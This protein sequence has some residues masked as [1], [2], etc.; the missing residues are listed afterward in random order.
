MPA[1]IAAM[2]AV[3]AMSRSPDAQHVAEQYMIEMHVGLD[4][5][6]EHQTEPEHARKDDAHHRILL[7]AAVVLEE[8][9]RDRAEDSGHEGTDRIGQADDIG[10]DDTREHGVADGVA[11]KRPAFQ[12][13]E[14]GEHGGRYG[15]QRR[16]DQRVDHE[17]ELERS[18]KGL[19][20]A[21]DGVSSVLAARRRAAII[22][23]FGAK[24]KA[25]RKI[26]V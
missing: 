25:I 26:A 18:E 13:E 6:V 2:I 4:L 3:S 5:D 11:H 23:C 24:K 15:D 1:V 12:H 22:P 9:R 19:D 14:A 20:N 21:H 8:T 10:D 17:A 16:D 7:D